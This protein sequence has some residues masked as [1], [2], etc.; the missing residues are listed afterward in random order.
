[1]PTTFQTALPLEVIEQILLMSDNVQVCMKLRS[2]FT[3]EFQEKLRFLIIKKYSPQHFYVRGDSDK[4]F[5][6]MLAMT[7]QR[8]RVSELLERNRIMPRSLH[9]MLSGSYHFDVSE[10]VRASKTIDEF[11]VPMAVTYTNVSTR[12]HRL[13]RIGDIMYGICFVSNVPVKACTVKVGGT[14]VWERTFLKP[15]R[16]MPMCAFAGGTGLCTALFDAPVYVLLSFEPTDGCAPHASVGCKYV[17]LS[18]LDRHDL[19]GQDMMIA[20]YDTYIH[21]T[22]EVVSEMHIKDR[23]VRTTRKQLIANC[24]T[25]SI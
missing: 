18:M 3:Q 12:S 10:Y 22:K 8:S 23:R 14:I 7:L 20:N 1:M 25:E 2:L 4:L 6:C 19:R 21:S 24:M 16:M 13:P 9:S 15:Q 11:R 5:G 17:M